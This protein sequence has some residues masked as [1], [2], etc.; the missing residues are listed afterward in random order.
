M[1]L[2]KVNL[3]EGRS[4]AEKEAIGAAV[5]AALVENLGVP[6]EDLYQIFNELSSDNFR[7]TDGYLG[8]TYTRQL[9]II[10]ITFLVGRSDDVK[11]AL[12]ADINR[13][14]V[15]AGVVSPVASTSRS[16]Y[17]I[18]AATATRLT[19]PNGSIAFQARAISWSKRNR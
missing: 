6:D 17:S 16:P 8:L 10:E 2:V 14:L 9:L 11:K 4:A 12:L 7:H 3:L 1:P 5:Q 13:N 18:H 15:T 19:T